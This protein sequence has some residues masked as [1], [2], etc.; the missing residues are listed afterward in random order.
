MRLALDTDVLVAGTRSD[1][2]ASKQLLLAALD[3]CYTLLVSVPLVL[4]YESV[5]TRPEHLTIAPLTVDEVGVLLDA[6]VGVGNPVRLSFRWRP[7]LSDPDDD[8]VLETAVN[9]AADLLVTFSRRHFT[10]AERQFHLRVVSP[11]E[12]L[13]LTGATT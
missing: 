5:L 1:L 13:V 3:G 10:R 4:Q 2:G 6:L 9:G 12:A 8:M 11:R 7:C